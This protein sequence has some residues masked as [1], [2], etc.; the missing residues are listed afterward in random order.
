MATVNAVNAKYSLSVS[1]ILRTVTEQTPR[2]PALIN[3]KNERAA[4]KNTHCSIPIIGISQEKSLTDKFP[5]MRLATV[6][7]QEKKSKTVKTHSGNSSTG[8]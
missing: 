1:E 7:L 2:N 6:T 8:R 5:N 4:E 3:N